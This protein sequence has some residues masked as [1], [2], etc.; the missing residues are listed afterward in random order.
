MTRSPSSASCATRASTD[1]R[2]VSVM[3][4][5]SSTASGAPFAATHAPPGS[6]HTALSRLRTGSNGYR[7]RCSLG[8]RSPA[9][10]TSARSTGSCAAA[11]PWAAA[12]TVSTRSRSPSMCSI[13]SRFSVSVPV[14]S[15]SS[16]VIAPTASA[17]RSRRRSTPCCARRRPPTATS[18]VTRIGSSSGIV[19]NASVSPSSS[20]SRAGWPRST[21]M[22]GTTTHAVTATMR[23]RA[24]QLGHGPLERRGRLPG[25]R[26]E[27]AEAADLGLGADRDDDALAGAGHHGGAGVDQR[28]PLGERRAGVDRLGPLGRRHG[29]AR[30]P[31][32]VGGQAVGLDDA[33][34]GGDDA[35]G[36]DEQHV[37]DR[38]A[39][40]PGLRSRRPPAGRAR[41]GR[42]GCATP[43]ARASPGPRISA[44]TALTSAMIA[45]MAIASRSSPKIAESTPTTTSSSWRGSTTDS[46]SSPR[47]ALVWL[48]SV[49]TAAVPRR[50]STSSAVR[51]PG[52][53][54]V[55][56][57]RVASGSAWT[58]ARSA[59]RDAG[60]ALAMQRMIRLGRNPEVTPVVWDHGRPWRVTG[61]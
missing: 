25:L 41:S 50:C 55:R 43:E 48:S 54:P 39:R 53:L 16:T 60:V 11:A 47:T 21:P 28:G 29:L 3:A 38:R 34:V 24:R 4:H 46:S 32:L 56:S 44:S 35:A 57:H 8:A 36:L 49:R 20:I 30:Q 26:D 7:P 61:C 2:S 23:A 15:A 9:A 17:A 19:A 5:A 58:G 12:A 27:P 13:S 6:R 59:G 37:A 14:L 31:G 22:S 33:G 45:K 52:R 18:T 10:S 42:S 1:A 51:P 40:R